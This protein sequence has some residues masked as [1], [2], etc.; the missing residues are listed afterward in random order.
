MSFL[1]TFIPATM[2]SSI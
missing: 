2:S 1:E